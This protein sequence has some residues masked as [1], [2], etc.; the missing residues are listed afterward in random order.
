MVLNDGANQYTFPT[1]GAKKCFIAATAAVNIT[2][3]VN[4]GRQAGQ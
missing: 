2:T 3:R 1:C 4:N